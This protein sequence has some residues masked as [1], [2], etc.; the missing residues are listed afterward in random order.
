MKTIAIAAMV[1]LFCILQGCA[2]IS[3]IWGTDVYKYQFGRTRV[4]MK[5]WDINRLVLLKPPVVSQNENGLTV[6]KVPL[7]NST[8]KKLDLMVKTRF[9]KTDPAALDNPEESDW[10][11]VLISE[12]STRTFQTISLGKGPF[13]DILIEVKFAKNE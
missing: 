11:R 10:Q 9:Y 3:G 1:C 8:S 4:E 5:G 13:N 6:V 12:K 2:V 7:E